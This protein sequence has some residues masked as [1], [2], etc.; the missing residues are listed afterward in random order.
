MKEIRKDMT[1]SS[2]QYDLILQWS[3]DEDFLQILADAKTYD[4]HVY[5]IGI[6]GFLKSIMAL[7]SYN[8]INDKKNLRRIREHWIPYLKMKKT[9]T[10]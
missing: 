3:K 6:V 2:E 7:N 4:R 5:V 1:L 9:L 8:T 10:Q